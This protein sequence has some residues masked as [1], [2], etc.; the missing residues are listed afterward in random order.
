[1][2]N[3]TVVIVYGSNDKVVR[4]DEKVLDLLN[5]DF[6]TVKI[7]RMDGLGHDPFEEDKGAFLSELGRILETK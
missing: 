6:P 1:M 5:T 3:T 7:L 2:P 4:V